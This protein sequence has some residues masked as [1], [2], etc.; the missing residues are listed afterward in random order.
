MVSD[1]VTD[2]VVIAVVSSTG[3]NVTAVNG[4]NSMKNKS[5]YWFF[6]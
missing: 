4:L 5:L 2:A 3:S 6:H 1:E